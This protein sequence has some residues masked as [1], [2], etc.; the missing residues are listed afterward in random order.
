MSIAL[1]ALIIALASLVWNIVSW[2]SSRPA[3]RIEPIVNGL[4]SGSFLDVDVQNRGGSAIAIT[5]VFVMF[6]SEGWWHR[7][8]SIRR[9]GLKRLFR[10]IHIRSGVGYKSDATEHGPGLPYTLQPYHAQNWTFDVP[11]LYKSWK[12]FPVRSSDC[13]IEIRLATGKT[14]EK[15][16]SPDYLFWHLEL[17]EPVSPDKP[18]ENKSLPY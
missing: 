16:I 9:G 12:R 13:L 15:K 2:K 1:A 17:E 11:S 6:E 10:R 4:G 8:Y 18:D 5:S 14:V 7:H 3:I